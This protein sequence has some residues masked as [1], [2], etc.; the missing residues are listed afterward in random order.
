MW[1]VR[2]A[3]RR[4]DSFIVLALPRPGFAPYLAD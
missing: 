3:L 2:V 4:P 1:V